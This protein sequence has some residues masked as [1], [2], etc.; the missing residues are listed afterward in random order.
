MF[1]QFPYSIHGIAALFHVLIVTICQMQWLFSDHYILQLLYFNL[2]V[3]MLS[4][5]FMS[6]CGHP[7]TIH[8]CSLL[9]SCCHHIP[10]AAALLF[11]PDVNTFMSQQLFLV[12][13]ANTS[14]TV[15]LLHLPVVTKSKS[16]LLCFMFSLPLHFL[17]SSCTLTHTCFLPCCFDDHSPQL[18]FSNTF[19]AKHSFPSSCSHHTPVKVALLHVPFI[20]TFQSKMLHSILLFSLHSG[21]SC[22]FVSSCCQHFYVTAAPCLHIPVG[23]H[24]IPVVTCHSVTL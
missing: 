11:V 10:V 6:S 7:T 21:H 4:P 9:S 2:S 20:T 12:L 15:A 3:A 22:S 13:V 16:P 14:I 18:L 1:L 23:L 17:P 5:L 24:H 19:L 8:S